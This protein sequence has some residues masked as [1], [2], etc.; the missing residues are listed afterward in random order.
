M[1]IISCGR[2]QSEAK[3]L[4][5]MISLYCRRHHGAGKDLCVE[6]RELEE[7]ALQRL[8]ACPFQEGKTTCGRCLVHCYRPAMRQRVREVMAEIG[9]KMIFHHPLM[10]LRH[11]I[12]G[13][14]KTPFKH[15]R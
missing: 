15:M 10:A 1:S 8:A 5:A 7:Y 9:P 4:K 3:T 11:L 12:D 6:C 2:M 14:R 13:L